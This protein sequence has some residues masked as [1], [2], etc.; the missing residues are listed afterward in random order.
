MLPKKIEEEL[1]KE[2]EKLNVSEE[3]KKKIKEKVIEKY[4]KCKIEPGEAIGIV[5]AQ[6]FGEPAT[7][8]ILRSFHFAGISELQLTLGLP[9]LIEILDA[10]KKPSTPSMTIYLKEPYNKDKEK[11]ME[12]A[13]KIKETKIEDISSSIAVDFLNK[14][15]EIHI[16]EDSLKKENLSYSIVISKIKKHVK[17]AE[18][19][20]ED[21]VIYIK[22]QKENVDIKKLYVLKE[23]LKSILVKGIKGIKQA[24]PV[25]DE[26]SGEYVIKTY[27]SNLEEVLKVEEV[28]ETRTYTNDIHEIEK[29]L[30]IEAARNAIV[31]E[32]LAVLE[33]QG[34]SVD[35]RYVL[36]VADIMTF[37]G[38]VMGVTRYGITGHKPSIF[39]RA[40]FEIPIKHLTMAAMFGE[41]DEIRGVVENVIINQ[42]APVGTGIV[43][44]IYAESKKEEN[45]RRNN[46]RNKK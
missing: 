29:V 20:I 33:E 21:N 44:L 41:K 34:L 22:M 12:V 3:L 6:S 28:D 26:N 7:Q 4:E 36:L 24:L 42:P 13:R 14:T 16:D 46:K 10:K 1:N 9:R 37:N 35:I 30:G 19:D 32:I 5:T 23:K 40:A 25:F 27:G 43:K 11:V 39:A 31:K 17:N 8:T 15:I 45:E 18:V 2:L 38:K